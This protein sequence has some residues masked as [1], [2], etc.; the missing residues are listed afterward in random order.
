M[1]MATQHLAPEAADMNSSSGKQH[2][3]CIYLW[4]K[5]GLYSKLKPVWDPLLHTASL[6]LQCRY[7]DDGRC[8]CLCVCVREKWGSDSAK[9]CRWRCHHT[10]NRRWKKIQYKHPLRRTCSVKL[11][12]SRALLFISGVATVPDTSSLLSAV[13]SAPLF[14]SISSFIFSFPA[15]FLT[16]FAICGKMRPVL[17]RGKP[18]QLTWRWI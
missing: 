16:A 15:C 7:H 2:Q 12:R 9:L 11:P 5:S 13:P 14:P 8:V 4:I 3:I 1:H 10:V 18:R 17:H 6:L